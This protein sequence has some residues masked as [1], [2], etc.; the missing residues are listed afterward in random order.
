MKKI[1]CI[2]WG[3]LLFG[4]CLILAI[5]LNIKKLIVTSINGDIIKDKVS[6]IITDAIKNSDV[7]ISDKNME[8]LKEKLENSSKTEEFTDKYVNEFVNSMID[9]TDYNIDVTNEFND[10][11]DSNKEELINSGVSESDINEIIKSIDDNADKINN[12]YNIGKE[13]INN[14][15]LDNTSNIF[16]VIEFICS[17]TLKYCLICSIVFISIIIFLI[18]W[19]LYS[20]FIYCGFSILM[21]GVMIRFGTSYAIN[22]FI[23]KFDNISAD[24]LNNVN[25]GVFNEISSIYIILGIIFII[26]YVILR[27]FSKREV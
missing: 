11:V 23:D 1:I 26:L 6:S 3:F 16:E 21:S 17:G 9:G 27:F 7:D 8:I 14:K 19:N 2:F 20:G 12:I 5:N 22:T 4:C 15:F 25:L 18:N 13:K 10:L 24:I